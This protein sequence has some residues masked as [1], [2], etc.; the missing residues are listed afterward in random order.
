MVIGEIVEILIQLKDRQEVLSR[1]E[2]ALI[3]ACD[4]LDQLPRMAEATEYKV[5]QQPFRDFSGRKG[6]ERNRKKRK[7]KKQTSF[8]VKNTHFYPQNRRKSQ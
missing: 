5:C 6:T 2:Q 1:E 7:R 8:T 4:L 3:Q